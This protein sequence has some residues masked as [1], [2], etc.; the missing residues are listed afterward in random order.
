MGLNGQKKRRG[1]P[2]KILSQLVDKSKKQLAQPRP[3]VIPKVLPSGQIVMKRPRGRPPKNPRPGPILLPAVTKAQPMPISS[4]PK[5]G[6]PR[7]F[8]PI[9]RSVASN[10]TSASAPGSQYSSSVAQALSSKPAGGTTVGV[11]SFTPRTPTPAS[12]TPTTK[13]TSIVPHL[14]SKLPSAPSPVGNSSTASS[15][16]NSSVPSNFNG[17][18]NKNVI[19][20][21][22][23]ASAGS[24]ADF[25]NN[26]DT[27]GKAAGASGVSQAPEAQRPLA[28]EE[29]E[30]EV[31]TFWKPPPQS[32][33]LLDQVVITDVTSG[34]LTIDRKSVV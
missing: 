30:M 14:V 27:S 7:K 17:D 6:R 26:R 23:N 22:S 29:R 19:A 20:L 13:Q 32:K 4:I 8:P 2:P 33:P 24:A 28:I 12:F 5:K 25:S 18:V 9:S 16:S 21:K 34:S 11:L 1:R 3:Q 31:R 15:D 10:N